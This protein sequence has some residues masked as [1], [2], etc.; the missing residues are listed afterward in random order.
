MLWDSLKESVLELG[1]ESNKFSKFSS[2][3][4]PPCCI[5]GFIDSSYVS[6]DLAESWQTSGLNELCTTISSSSCELSYLRSSRNLTCFKIWGFVMRCW[7]SLTSIFSIRSLASSEI[8]CGYINDPLRI[9]LCKSC[10]LDP[11]KGT[12]PWRIVNK[13]TPNDQIST[14]KPL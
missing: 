7:G 11:L 8:G 10:R 3:I 2:L 13:R 14:A 4:L 6:L 12:V 5:I 1:S 9:S